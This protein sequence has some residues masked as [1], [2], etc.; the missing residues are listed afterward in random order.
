MAVVSNTVV[1]SQVVSVP[2]GGI[3][4]GTRL[5]VP[6]TFLLRLTNTPDTGMN[7]F[8]ASRRC[9]FWDFNAASKSL[10]YFRCKEYQISHTFTTRW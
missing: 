1:G 10:C 3:A 4:D 9:A 8:I 7:E 2:V 5:N 6:V